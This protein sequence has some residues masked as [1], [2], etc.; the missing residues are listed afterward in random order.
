[1]GI[2]RSDGQTTLS[3]AGEFDASCVVRYERLFRDALEDST[4]LL[5]VDMTDVTF[6]DSTG[7]GM[8]VRSHRAADAA[9]AR[10][11]VVHPTAQTRKLI[12]VLGLDELLH[13]HDS[14]EQA[15]AA[16]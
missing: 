12:T 4:A 6:I 16:E 13:V 5:V 14:P 2:E 8:L 15:L 7:L 1:M 3:L 10:F 9:S 11:A